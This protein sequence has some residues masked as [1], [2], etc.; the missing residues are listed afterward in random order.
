MSD[1]YSD[2]TGRS[3]LLGVC[4]GIAA[5]KSAMLVRLLKKADARVQV[6]MT[7][8]AARFITPV[9][10]GTLSERKVLVEVFPENEDGSWTKHVELGLQADLFIIAPATAQTIAK[11][12][13]G[14]S[15]SM[16]TATA[17]SARCPMLV[18][19]AMDR[20]MYAHPAVQENME[21]LRSFGWHV[22]KAEH[23]E[24]ASGL[25]GQGRLPE[26]EAILERAAQIIRSAPEALRA[27]SGKN[28]SGML[29]GRSVLVTAGPTHETIDPVRFL[30]NPST[31][32][33][34]YALAK[35]ASQQSAEVTLVSGPTNL[36][37]PPDVSNIEV[38]SANEMHEAVQAHRNADIVFM[39]AAVADYTPAEPSESKTKKTGDDWTLR[40]RRTPDILAT[41]GESKRNGQLLV[42]FALETDDAIENA[43]EKLKKKNLDWIVLNDASETGAG[44]GAET[45]RVTLISRKGTEETLPL[46]SKREVAEAILERI[47][48]EN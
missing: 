22:M 15:D 44:F 23:G 34:G 29:E 48:K 2:L 30:T 13:H 41:L 12:A 27:T 31:G 36:N 9:T 11:L 39:A 17:L 43:R 1:G 6:L 38:T 28:A 25:E 21:R 24:L 35:A 40:L 16:L 33:M 10:L 47:I 19:P 45:N 5:Y 26:P 20:D 46:M 32:T 4:G 3:I 7:P 42:G 14:F 37:A 8:N 18:C